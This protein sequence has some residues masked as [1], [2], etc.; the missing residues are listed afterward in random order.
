MCQLVPPTLSPPVNYD[1][2]IFI[3]IFVSYMQSMDIEY[4]EKHV[5]VKGVN[6]WLGVWLVT[7]EYC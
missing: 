6:T 5:I 1:I 7:S 4:V 3:Y 2:T